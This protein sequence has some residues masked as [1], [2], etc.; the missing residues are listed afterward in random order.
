MMESSSNLDLHHQQEIHGGSSSFTSQSFPLLGGFHEWHQ[1][2][3]VNGGE[4]FNSN[5]SGVLPS[6][7]GFRLSTNEISAPPLG[8]QDLGFHWTGI[9]ESYM[10]HSGHQHQEN[11]ARI[12]EEYLSQSYPKLTEFIKGEQG[13][14]E[15]DERL[16]LDPTS[17]GGTMSNLSSMNQVTSSSYPAYMGMDLQAL[18]L[19]A[20]A[21]FGRSFCEPTLNSMELIRDD[22]PFGLGRI[23]GPT[24]LP[25][26]NHHQTPSFASGVSEAKR[27]NL[28][29]KASQAAPKKP[30]FEARSSCTSF[31]VRKEKLGDRIAALQQLVA[32]F[33]KTDTASVLMEAIGYI[34]FLQEQVE[35]LSVPYM[36]T[37]K[38]LRT[39]QGTSSEDGDEEKPD[40]SSRGLCLVPLSCTSYV[41]SDNGG[42]WSPP[43]YRGTN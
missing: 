42:T 34:K 16:L 18:D 40:L 6:S 13:V 20:S 23:Q 31:K 7:R 21:R 35:T 3:I 32:P 33:G 41:T 36:R 37:N 22:I 5:A 15:L 17:F 1:D 2:L 30:R 25:P 14:H 11:Q 4:Q 10:N 26:N 27:G 39:T 29:N 24:Q 43:N 38:R 9:S 28:E 8:F 19:L 12:K